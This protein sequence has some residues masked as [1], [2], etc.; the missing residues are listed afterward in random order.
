VVWALETYVF[1][2]TVPIPI[3]ALIDIAIPA[4][5]AFGVGYAVH[6]T[7]RNDPDARQGAGN[8]PTVP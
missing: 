5:A 1:K 4:I 7:W 2:G 8:P 3:Q 6:H